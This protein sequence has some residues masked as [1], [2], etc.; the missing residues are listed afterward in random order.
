M[1]SKKIIVE[2]LKSLVFAYEGLWILV[3][4]EDSF[5]YQL[6]GCFLAILA[7]FYFEIT[8][9]EWLAQLGIMALVL[10]LEG[11][12]TAIEKLA[13][14]VQPNQDK[15]IAKVKDLAAG[16]VLVAGL[17]ALAIILIIYIPYLVMLF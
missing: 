7:G 12:N 10:G 16:A 1:F 4:K 9:V 6:L 8:K 2:R 17:F 3:F 5:K 14:Y 11:L 13:D 15:A